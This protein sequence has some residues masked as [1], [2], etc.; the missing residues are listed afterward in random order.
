MLAAMP[1]A[2]AAAP[3]TPITFAFLHERIRAAVME[4][5]SGD[6]NPSDPLR[7]LYISDDQAVALAETTGPDLE[8]RL[9]ETAQ[10]LGLDALDTAVLALC[11][12]PEIDPR[13][14]RLF[15]YLHDDV[16][17]KLL[18]PRLCGEL[19]AVEGVSVADV[20]SCFGPSGRLMRVGA[21]RLVVGDGTTPLADRAV[22]TA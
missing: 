11:A 22:K 14:G 3:A 21:L 5:A 13:Y 16:T 17:R 9:A 6:A 15:A 1:D 2:Q 4:A 18:S 12:A 10:R 7:G 8:A 20:L 19:L